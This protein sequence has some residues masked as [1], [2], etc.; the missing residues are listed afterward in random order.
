MKAISNV[1]AQFISQFKTMVQ[2][3]E[4]NHGIT[5]QTVNLIANADGTIGYDIQ[6]VQADGEP[7]PKPAA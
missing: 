2:A 1:E 3:F 7:E 4:I 6:L 5:F